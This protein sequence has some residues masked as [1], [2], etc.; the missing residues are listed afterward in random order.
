MKDQRLIVILELMKD[1]IDRIYQHTWW[2]A[3][4]IKDNHTVL[5]ACLM[6]L[7]H[8]WELAWRLKKKYPDFMFPVVDIHRLVWLRN[9]IAHDYL[10][11]NIWIMIR[12]IDKNLPELHADIKSIL[13]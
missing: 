10:S 11:I 1:S 6:Q 3:S 7:V 4:I 13:Q 9:L 2:N 12:I 8:I 5:D